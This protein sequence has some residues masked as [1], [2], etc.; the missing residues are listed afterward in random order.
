MKKMGVMV[1]KMLYLLMVLS[2]A[3]LSPAQSV[4]IK[5]LV[6]IKGNRS[7]QLIGLG[8]VVGLSNT[9]D[10]KKSLGTNK[11]ISN[12]IARLGLPVGKDDVVSGSAAAVIVTGYLPPFS[13]NGDQIDIKVSTIGGGTL[14]QTPLRA[15]DGKIYAVAQGSIAMGRA[16]GTGSQTLTS[17]L[18][19]HGAY[20]EREYLPKLAID[21]KITLSLKKSDFTNN[22]RITDKINSY[23]KG[24]FAKSNDPSSI[25]VTVPPSYKDRVIEF[26]SNMEKLEVD[27]DMPA[28]VV[29]NEK[30][31]TLV[32]G[33]RV[34]ISPIVIA[35]GDLSINVGKDANEE[36]QKMVKISGTS[37]GDLVKS[38]NALGVK[39][40]DLVSILQ[41]IDG[42]GAL[43][44]QLRFL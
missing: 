11:A 13:R 42:A 8:L 4:R 18:V 41:A 43:R 1:R 30:T 14:I 17:A 25:E 26:V 38:L 44:G 10:S 39:P 12:L 27:T 7:N 24:F 16:S 23:F 6:N 34:L 5:E 9:G 37:V 29:L 21:G 36:S 28:V 35:H 19:N 40:P 20:V 31:G 33:Q 15:G 2:L 3:G 22:T 32:M